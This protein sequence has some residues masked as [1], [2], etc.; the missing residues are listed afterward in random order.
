MLQVVRCLTG[1][2]DTSWN[3]GS[4]SQRG[5]SHFGNTELHSCQSNRFLPHSLV[6]KWMWGVAS[7]SKICDIYLLLC[8]YINILV[9]ILQSNTP[10]WQLQ[11]WWGLEK[12]GKE[13]KSLPFSLQCNE[14]WQCSS[15]SFNGGG[16][17][18]QSFAWSDSGRRIEEDALYP[19][20]K[21]SHKKMPGEHLIRWK[22]K[23][24]VSPELLT[25]ESEGGLDPTALWELT[26]N[27]PQYYR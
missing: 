11:Q 4:S 16:D 15:L 23:E 17:H 27:K 14:R 7:L 8:I 22:S 10:L 5:C 25:A 12:K 20:C 18:D 6:G 24:A 13:E 1:W 2:N 21:K 19:V 26:K 3:V 9:F